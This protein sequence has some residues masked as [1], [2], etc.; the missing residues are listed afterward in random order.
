MP[1]KRKRQTALYKL[2]DS[3]PGNIAFN[4]ALLIRKLRPVFQLDKQF[5]DH[6]LKAKVIEELEHRSLVARTLEHATGILV[7]IDDPDYET[8]EEVR[9]A[10][11]ALEATPLLLRSRRKMQ[12]HIGTV[13]RLVCD[14]KAFGTLKGVR[15]GFQIRLEVNDA[16]HKEWMFKAQMCMD[17]DS[18][19]RAFQEL[20]SYVS[21]AE[22]MR[23]RALGL[24]VT[25]IL[26]LI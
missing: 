17:H 4:V 6:R 7:W 26:R 23:M 19:S 3:L 14:P 5:G 20:M 24:H 16:N 13:L 15:K 11:A 21:I 18:I 25:R 8:S 12:R 1:S 2:Q 22:E 9:I 10:L